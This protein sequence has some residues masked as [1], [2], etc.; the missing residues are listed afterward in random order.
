MSD[1][2]TNAAPM[3]RLSEEWWESR[4]PEVRARRC[5]AH[6][7]N[8][9]QCAKVAMQAQRVCG[10]HGGRAPQAKSKARQR[11]EEAADRLALRALSIAQSDKVPAYV[12]LQA[13]QDLL[14][15]AGVSAK[16]AVAVEVEV[17]PYEE[18]LGLTGIAQITRAESRELRGLPAPDP[19]AP[20]DA[21]VVEAPETAPDGSA[22]G[23]TPAD[24][25]DALPMRP[26]F[27]TDCHGPRPGNA[28]MTLEQANAELREA[29]LRRRY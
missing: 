19:A 25:S 23:R 12:A 24:R 14:D 8:G 11:I 18:L 3:E 29:R 16:T 2:P 15:R 21:E 28:L 1:D 9:A 6:R 17:K 7:R 4:A 22:H 20:I 27:A 10:T 5:T 13:T 26:A